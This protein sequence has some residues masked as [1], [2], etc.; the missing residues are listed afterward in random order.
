MLQQ[1]DKIFIVNQNK[2]TYDL[3]LRFFAFFFLDVVVLSLPV[4]F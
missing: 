1:T 2:K 3:I 4:P